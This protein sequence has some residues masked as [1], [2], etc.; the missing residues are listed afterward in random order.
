V[1]FPDRL[2]VAA[3]FVLGAYHLRHRVAV[4]YAFARKAV[5]AEVQ[6]AAAAGGS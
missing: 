4:A 1:C 2:R 6:A 5:F 3:A